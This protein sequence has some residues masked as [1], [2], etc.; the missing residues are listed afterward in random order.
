[1]AD[2]AIGI[3][4][5]AVEALVNK[6]NTAIKE[7]AELWKIVHYDTVFMKD[8]FE[9]MQSFLKTADW[10]QVK[11][12]VGRTWVRQVRELSYDAEDSIDALVLLDNKRSLRTIWRRFWASC[13]CD[14]GVP[15]KLELAVDEIKLLKARVEEVS[16]RNKRYSLINDSGATSQQ[17]AC[18]PDAIG[19]TEAVDIL[20]EA[21]STEQKLGGSVNLSMLINDSNNSLRVITLR[22]TG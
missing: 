9:M 10:E 17:L 18:I 2:L 5:T 16:N 3:S 22:N 1:M 11:N 13:N 19:T 15:S 12:T 7:E 20:T 4:K 21:W 6:V 14:C 8:E